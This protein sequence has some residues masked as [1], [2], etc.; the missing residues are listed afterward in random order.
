[1]SA[2]NVRSEKAIMNAT[3]VAVSSLPDALVWRNNTGQ[4]WQGGRVQARVGG[5]VTVQPGMVILANARPVSFG[6]VGSADIIGAIQGRPVAVESKARSGRQ[7]PEQIAFERQWVKSG[8]LYVL[9]GSENEAIE[10]L[11]AGL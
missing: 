7:E 1:M 5:T 6:L 3:L 10:G 4:A 8:G 11:L 9:A 2:R